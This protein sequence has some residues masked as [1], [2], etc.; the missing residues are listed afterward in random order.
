MTT[1]TMTAPKI[2]RAMVNVGLGDRANEF[3][4]ILDEMELD[5]RLAIS[6]A[7]ADRGEF[8]PMEELMREL[9]E[10]FAEGYYGQI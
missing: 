5:R 2:K 1:M 8:V 9:D 7:Q 4:S 6:M 10:E 3:L